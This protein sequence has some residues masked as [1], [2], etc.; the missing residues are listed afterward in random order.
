MYLVARKSFNRTRSCLSSSDRLG[1]AGWLPSA[2]EIARYF[3]AEKAEKAVETVE[4]RAEAEG[5]GTRV[6]AAVEKTGHH[7][8]VEDLERMEDPK[9]PEA[10][11]GTTGK[12]RHRMKAQ[13]GRDGKRQHQP[14]LKS[15]IEF[16]MFRLRIEW[17]DVDGNEG[18]EFPLI[19]SASLRGPPQRPRPGWVRVVWCH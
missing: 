3:P 11:A 13:E 17:G 4:S 10:D 9:E 16:M 19:A 12:L 1:L 18:R 15:P 14:V 8:S 6:Y 2:T 5:T 7:R